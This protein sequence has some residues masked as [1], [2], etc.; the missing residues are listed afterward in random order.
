VEFVSFPGLDHPP[1]YGRAYGEFK[2]VDHVM[3]NS[4]LIRERPASA[5]VWKITGRYRVVNLRQLI[6]RAPRQYDLYCNSRNWPFRWLDLGL[7]GWSVAGYDAT[8]RG[9]YPE[10]REDLLGD[11]PEIRMRSLVD[12]M[13]PQVRIVRRYTVE[14]RIDGIRGWDG[15]SYAHGINGLKFQVRRIARIVA[16]WIWI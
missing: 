4:R 10:L 8:L 15:R 7:I 2:L 12:R 13:D 16:P 1:A 6:L 5:K 14:P 3:S 11:P 9:I